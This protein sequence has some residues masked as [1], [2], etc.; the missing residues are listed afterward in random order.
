[1]IPRYF[2]KNKGSEKQIYYYALILLIVKGNYDYQYLPWIQ[3]NYLR[4]LL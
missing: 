2:S 3:K 1:V 4:G